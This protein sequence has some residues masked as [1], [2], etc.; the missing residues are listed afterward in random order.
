MKYAIYEDPDTHRFAV[1]RLP[2]RFAQGDAV[3]LPSSIRW[4]QTRDEVIATLSELFDD[5]DTRVE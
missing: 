1:V 5:E 2:P 4:F 3:P